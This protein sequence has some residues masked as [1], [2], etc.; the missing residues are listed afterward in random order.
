MKHIQFQLKL[1]LNAA[2]ASA[3]SCV[4]IANQTQSRIIVCPTVS[5]RTA[6]LLNW[7]RPVNPI[8]AVTT[9]IRTERILRTQRGVIALLYKGAATPYTLLL[10]I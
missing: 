1:P 9:K 4:F 8:I 5:G 6:Y 2:E 3:I 7:L 10:R